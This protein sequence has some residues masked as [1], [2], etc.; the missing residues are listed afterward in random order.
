MI[1][2]IFQ[3]YYDDFTKESNDKGFL[4]LDN[5]SNTRKDWSE[6]WPIRNYLLNNTLEN[7]TYYAFLSP[8]FHEKTGLKSEQVINILSQSNEDVVSFSPFFD[9]SAFFLNI[10]YQGA[11]NH[12]SIFECF[13]K[14]IK[15]ID[16]KHDVNQI[17]MTSKN[18]IF[19]NFFAAKK[20][21]WIAWFNICEVLFKLS[22]ENN[23]DL[24]KALNKNVS[25][26]QEFYPAKVF[27][28]ERIISLLLIT[29]KNFSVKAFNPINLPFTAAGISN[30]KNILIILDA[31]KISFVETNA[32]EY[33]ESYLEIRSN[34]LS[35]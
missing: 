30:Y 33:I 9:Q 35:K 11:A 27:I 1:N 28:I 5:I 16:D 25:H 18:T 29:H 34:L 2:K 23:T 22:E 10:F 7:N 17:V 3:I 24:A 13:E 20:Q 19:C 32:P 4:Q 15:F 21:V 8:K 26:S 31:L 14:V 12:P 6:Y